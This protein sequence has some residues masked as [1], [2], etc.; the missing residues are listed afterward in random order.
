MGHTLGKLGC[1]LYEGPYARLLVFKKST[2]PAVTRIRTW[3]TSATTKGTNHYTIT[4]TG[5]DENTSP[6]LR[7][8]FLTPYIFVSTP[9]IF[10][11]KREVEV[12]VGVLP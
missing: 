7:N 5:T 9:S 4:A 1:S 8:L 2:V 12:Q 11:H 3:V 10:Y 6:F